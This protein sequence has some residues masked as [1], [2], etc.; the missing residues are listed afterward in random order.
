MVSVAPGTM[1]HQFTVNITNDNT[2]ECTETFNLSISIEKT[3]CGLSSNNDDAQVI[4][5]DDDGKYLQL[6]YICN[7]SFNG[8]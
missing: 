8:K 7:I 6:Y 4:I 1:A 3:L 2:I 5:I